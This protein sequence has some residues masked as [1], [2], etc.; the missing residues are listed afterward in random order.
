MRSRSELKNYQL[1][2]YHFR[3]RLIVAMVVVV[4]CFGILASRF[5]YLQFN[6]YDYYQTLAENNRISLVP[7][8]PNRGLILDRNGVILANNFFVYTLEITPSKLKDVEAT[9]ND[10]A[11]F[12]EISTADRKQ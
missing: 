2:N 6:R 12:V 5:F 9:I 4:I 3:I 10:L 11:R 8:V 7:I 1:E